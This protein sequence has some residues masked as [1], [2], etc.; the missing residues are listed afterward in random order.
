MKILKI[1][2][3]F[4]L[5][6]SAFAGEFTIPIQG[7]FFIP[8]QLSI[9]NYTTTSPGDV[10]TAF[11][12]VQENVLIRNSVFENQS[13]ENPVPIAQVFMRFFDP[14]L[15]SSQMETT[16]FNISITMSA[17]VDNH[18]NYEEEISSNSTNGVNTI[19]SGTLDDERVVTGNYQCYEFGTSSYLEANAQ[20]WSLRLKILPVS[21]NSNSTTEDTLSNTVVINYI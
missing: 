21:S 5:I 14:A 18:W 12:T 17:S 7:K 13:V 3:Y 4:F 19:Y 6:G 11:Y 9:A 1:L 10:N 16:P 8:S 20:Y 15:E 2:V